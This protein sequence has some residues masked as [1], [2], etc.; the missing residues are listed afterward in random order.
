MSGRTEPYAKS[1]SEGERHPHT[2]MAKATLNMLTHISASE[3]AHHV[4][5]I[6]A[7]DVGWVTDEY[8]VQLAQHKEDVHGFQPPLDIVDGAV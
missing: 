1:I 2:N 6:N 7:V 5:Y 4:I 3:L 8:P